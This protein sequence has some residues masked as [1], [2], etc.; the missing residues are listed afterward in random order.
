[1]A[2][3]PNQVGLV[4]AL[5]TL[6]FYLYGMLVSITSMEKNDCKM[7]Y[8]F[9]YPQFVVNTHLL[10]VVLIIRFANLTGN[11]H[12]AVNKVASC[13]CRYGQ[14]SKISDI[15]V[16]LPHIIMSEIRRHS[17]H[18]QYSFCWIYSNFT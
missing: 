11:K 15:F 2:V 14:Y 5:L 17:L 12:L 8:M 1:M 10:L 4:V 6:L 16:I 7:T 3:N 13:A 18:F 9:E